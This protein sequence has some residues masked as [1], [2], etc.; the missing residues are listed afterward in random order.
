[1]FSFQLVKLAQQLKIAYLYHAHG[2]LTPQGNIEANSMFDTHAD[3][4]ENYRE[5][6]PKI[7][8][9]QFILLD[10][11]FDQQWIRWWVSGKDFGFEGQE[12]SFAPLHQEIKH[13]LNLYD[14][15][16]VHLDLLDNQNNV[17]QALHFQRPSAAEKVFR[18]RGLEGLKAF[19]SS[20]STLRKFL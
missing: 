10:N 8:K 18:E 1:M 16:N 5:R 7:K 12:K 4:L 20:G 9:D 3:I 6:F 17:I 15:A 11:A 2:W 13:L 19:L 14:T